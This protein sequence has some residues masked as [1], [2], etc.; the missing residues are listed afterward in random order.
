VAALNDSATRVRSELAG[1]E[2]RRSRGRVPP[3]PSKIDSM[4]HRDESELTT[5]SR[6]VAARPAP[7]GAGRSTRLTTAPRSSA[8]HHPA[9]AG[10]SRT[11]RRSS[12]SSVVSSSNP[13]GTWSHS[14]I[15]LVTYLSP[16]VCTAPLVALK[17]QHQP[18]HSPP[19]R[20]EST[21]EETR[22]IPI[23]ERH[24]CTAAREGGHRRSALTT[25]RRVWTTHPRGGGRRRCRRKC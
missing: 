8:D 7:D 25:Q 11:V 4:C 16:I 23:V 2:L 1:S 14:S 13:R 21:A 6:A 3:R 18:A 15:W 5:A 20:S 12:P 17:A 19:T 24:G 22:R 10:S 9:S